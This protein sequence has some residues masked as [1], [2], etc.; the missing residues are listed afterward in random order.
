MVFRLFI[1][2]I[3]TIILVCS[4]YFLTDVKTALSPQDIVAIQ[5]LNLDAQC[6]DTKSFEQELNCIHA[7]QYT[8]LEKVTDAQCTHDAT[9]QEPADFLKRG[10]GCCFSRS[11]LIEKTLGYYGFEVRHLSIHDLPYPVIGYFMPVAH[12]HS[13]SE[14]LT[15]KGWMFVDSNAPFVLVTTNGEPLDAPTFLYGDYWNKVTVKPVPEGLFRSK[16]SVF[17]GLYSRHGR[18]YAP[19]VPLPDIDW[20]QMRYNLFKD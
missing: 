13:A 15:R 9:S 8:Q 14:V 1:I 2:F 18:F 12:S 4:T 20:A 19:F 3:L 10:Y 7:V 16:P 17:Y 11:R 6:K 5:S